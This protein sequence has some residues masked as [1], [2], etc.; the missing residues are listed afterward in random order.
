MTP[1]LITASLL[2][3]CAGGDATS[4]GDPGVQ[5]PSEDPGIPSVTDPEVGTVPGLGST[6]Q[7][8][9]KK[10][11]MTVA[12]VRDSMVQIT[13]GVTWGDDDQST[14]DTYGATLGVAD[15]QTRTSN[16]R[17]PSV[18][19]MKFLDDAAVQTCLGWIA[20]TDGSFFEMEDPGS[21]DRDAVRENIVGLRWQIQGRPRG[22]DDP[23]VDDY[24]DLFATVYRR[25]G[26]PPDAWHAVCVGMFTHPDFFMY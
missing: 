24:L 3:G 13:G 22:A 16:D 21:V 1:L 23:L 18:L 25:T 26:A 12:Q 4:D 19:F 9:R 11:R 10:R 5:A 8:A 17:T 20:D 15:Y 6:P 7:N 14:W 2:W